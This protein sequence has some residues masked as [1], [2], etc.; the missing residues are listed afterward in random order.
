MQ[1][2]FYG[3]GVGPGDPELLTIKA[4]RIMKECDVIAV[5]VSNPELKM[6]VYIE[7]EKAAEAENEKY[8][9]YIEQCMAYQIAVAAVPEIAD[10]SRLLYPMPMMKQKEALRKIHDMCAE[11]SLEILEHE[12]NIACI[13]LGDPTVYSTCLYVQKRLKRIGVRTVLV[14]GVTSF[15]AAAAAVGTGLAENREMLHIIPASYETE[16][17]VHLKGT[18]VLMKAGSRLSLVKEQID[19]KQMSACMVENCGMDNER[20]YENAAEIPEQAGYYS[21]LIAK[22]K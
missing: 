18:K 20:I 21:L 6:P 22:N 9:Q 4:V 11:K 7:G 10:K 17:W 14:P 19:K 8:I 12:Q 3:I 5:A 16:E 13:T 1:G 2:I 15:C